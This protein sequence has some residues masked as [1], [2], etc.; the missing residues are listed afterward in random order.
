MTLVEDYSSELCNTFVLFSSLQWALNLENGPWPLY[1]TK[2]EEPEE[3]V[4]Y[5]YFILY[6][7]TV[8][9]HLFTSV[10]AR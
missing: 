9:Y 5:W 1:I 10:E 3:E 7:A 2:E 6:L 4:S 8:K